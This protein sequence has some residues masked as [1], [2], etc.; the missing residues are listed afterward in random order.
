[1]IAVNLPSAAVQGANVGVQGSVGSTDNALVRADGTTGQNV[2]GSTVTMS[3]A[4][5]IT[6]P[7]GADIL[8]SLGFNVLGTDGSG[9][10]FLGQTAT[11]LNLFVQ[12]PAARD[13]IFQ[14][15]PSNTVL[16]L[17]NEKISAA[18]P[19]MF[20]S[21]T[22]AQLEAMSPAA[23]WTAFATDEVTGAQLV[24]YDGSGWVLVASP[25]SSM[26]DT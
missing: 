6:L 10:V 8:S 4:G 17:E 18:R 12:C 23:G 7:S 20:P 21:Y 16:T 1:M 15:G 2:Q 14:C 22:V 9:N 13:I 11:M 5:N 26:S 24:V 25:L 19:F 3:D